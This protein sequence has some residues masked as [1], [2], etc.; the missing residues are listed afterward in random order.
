MEFFHRSK[1]NEFCNSLLKQIQKHLKMKRTISQSSEEAMKKTKSEESIDQLSELD[2]YNRQSPLRSSQHRDECFNEAIK[3]VVSP[4]VEESNSVISNSQ[5]KPPKLLES[6]QS[7]TAISRLHEGD[8]ANGCTKQILA[9]EVPIPVE[10]TP[11]ILLIFQDR[12]KCDLKQF[13]VNV[14]TEMRKCFDKYCSLT[15]QSPSTL[16]FFT[17]RRD[18]R[19]NLHHIGGNQTP[20]S[21]ALQNFDIVT[22][23]PKTITFNFKHSSSAKCGA[24]F[25]LR[26][27]C[28]TT[29]RDAYESYAHCVQSSVKELAFSLRRNEADEAEISC[30]GSDTPVTLSLL[31]EH[32]IIVR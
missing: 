20:I 9:N 10:P 1:S 4:A 30:R 5:I 19:R 21:L 32:V 17:S 22:A 26:L 31:D 6:N 27:S 23:F 28:T 29:M 18:Q 24:V 13:H 12:S 8:V 14:T 7:L 15:K 3:A 16:L 11:K 25:R 2:S